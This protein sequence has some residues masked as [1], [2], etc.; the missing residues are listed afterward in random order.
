MANSAADKINSILKVTGYWILFLALLIP[1][2]SQSGAIFSTHVHRFTFGIF[3]TAIAFLITWLFIKSEKKSFTE[4][5][6]VWK[7]NTP[8]EFF[9]GLIIGIASFTASHF[10]ISLICWY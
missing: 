3:G 4:Y 7:K 6:L 5:N 10:D 8:L 1:V 2:T 9:Q